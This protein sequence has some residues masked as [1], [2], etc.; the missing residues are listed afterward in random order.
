MKKL[1]QLSSFLFLLTA[2]CSNNDE[3]AAAIPE[4]DLDAFR[5]FIQSTLNGDYEKARTLMLADSTNT[6]YFD[7]A[8]RA[9]NEKVSDDL[10][11][12]Y[13]KASINIHE[14]KKMNDSVTV[15]SYSNSLYKKDTHQLKVLKINDRWLVDFK[16]YFV[17]EKDSLP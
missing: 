13:K 3:K 4:D 2:G 11:D 9:Y 14:V 17:P 1:F 5:S 16:Y 7:V 8:E 12:S 10:K 6:Q 15:I